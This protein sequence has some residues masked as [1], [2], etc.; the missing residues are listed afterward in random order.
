M[1]P[2]QRQLDQ[3]LGWLLESWTTRDTGEGCRFCNTPVGDVPNEEKFC[4]ETCEERF[5]Q[6]ME[7][8]VAVGKRDLQQRG[9]D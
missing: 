8:R 1:N 4:D 5:E 3:E 7:A 2:Q 9:Y 6:V